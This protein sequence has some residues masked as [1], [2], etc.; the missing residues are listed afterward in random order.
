[1]ETV[2]G[3]TR[4]RKYTYDGAGRLIEVR[5]ASDALVGE[6]AYDGNGNR[7]KAHDGFSYVDVGVNLGCPDGTG[8]D[9]ADAEDRLCTYG[10][11]DYVYDDNGALV[12]KTNTV[13]SDVETYEYDGLGRLL[14]ATV[15][16]KVID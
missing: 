7:T 16:G 2:E 8:A 10:N 13:T 9:A 6:Y 12:S 4:V 1:M 5:D 15:P 11:W 3:N 14:S